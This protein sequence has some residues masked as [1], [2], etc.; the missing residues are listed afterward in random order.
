MYYFFATV[1]INQS[2]FRIINLHKFMLEYLQQSR[3]IYI[4]FRCNEYIYINIVIKTDRTI[5]RL[6][7]ARQYIAK[8]R[9]IV[10]LCFISEGS[11]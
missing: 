7:V 1:I 10:L 9:V 4:K 6:E 8:T 3:E 2:I 11:T 5:L